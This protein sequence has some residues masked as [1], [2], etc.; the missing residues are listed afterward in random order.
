MNV[1]YGQMIS[2]SGGN[3]NF[4]K[5]DMGYME[6][7]AMQGVVRNIDAHISYTNV[8]GGNDIIMV[9]GRFGFLNQRFGIMISACFMENH[10]TMGMVGI[11]IKPIKNNPIS[12]VYSQSSDLNLKQIGIKFPLLNSHYKSSPFKK[13]NH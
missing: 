4:M 11:D 3:L 2:V 5:N 9:G 1:T 13:M 8:M 7:E 12:I 6:V 10:K